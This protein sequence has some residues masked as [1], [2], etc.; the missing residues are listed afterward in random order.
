MVRH[1][2][3]RTFFFNDDDSCSDGGDD[4]EVSMADGVVSRS[5]PRVGKMVTSVVASCK[6]AAHG[7]CVVRTKG[8][9]IV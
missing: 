7:S 2:D 9:V 8:L 3:D 6:S 4:S 5:I 1:Y